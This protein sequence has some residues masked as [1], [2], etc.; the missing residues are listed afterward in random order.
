MFLKGTE[1]YKDRVTIK[2][3]G[4]NGEVELNAPAYM[5][6]ESSFKTGEYITRLQKFLGDLRLVYEGLGE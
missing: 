2:V 5:M 3:K 1:K 6:V 4:R